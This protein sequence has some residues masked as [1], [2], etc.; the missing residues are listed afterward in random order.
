MKLISGA[1]VIGALFTIHHFS[2][3]MAQQGFEHG[4]ERGIEYEHAIEDRCRKEIGNDYDKMVF[5]IEGYYG[6]EEAET[7]IEGGSIYHPISIW[8]RV[9][10]WLRGGS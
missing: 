4:Y 7:F 6:T 3:F 8:R 1:L 10:I 2:L 9:Y 5:C